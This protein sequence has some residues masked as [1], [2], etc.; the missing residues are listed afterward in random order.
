MFY[1]VH[2]K[3]PRLP[4]G[5]LVLGRCTQTEEKGAALHA[6]PKRGWLGAFPKTAAELQLCDNQNSGQKEE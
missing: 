2:E 1:S 5:K 4:E 3:A 6:D